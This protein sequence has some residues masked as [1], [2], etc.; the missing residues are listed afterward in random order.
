MYALKSF[1]S[2]RCKKRFFFLFFF[3][4]SSPHG[5]TLSP[6]FGVCFPLACGRRMNGDGR[7]WEPDIQTFSGSAFRFFRAKTPLVGDADC[8]LERP[9]QI[10]TGLCCNPLSVDA[11][12]HYAVWVGEGTVV[13]E[14]GSGGLSMLH[15][16][17]L[18]DHPALGLG[19]NFRA[20]GLCKNWR[21]PMHQPS[22]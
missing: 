7:V 8:L 11:T 14:W 13:T 18:K 17:D 16:T 6:S 21:K 22:R 2:I 15:P 19:N 20:G 10:L 9:P 12:W 4:P 5:S 3:F 1:F